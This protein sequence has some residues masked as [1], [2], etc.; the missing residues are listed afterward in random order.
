VKWTHAADIKAQLERD[1]LRGEICRAAVNT[2]EDFSMSI[3][4]ARPSAKVMLDEFSNMQDW[5]KEM[6]AFAAKRSVSLQWNAINHRVL[7]KQQLP[8]AVL[9]DS[10][11]QAAGLI[12]K[13]QALKQFIDL[14]KRTGKYFDRLQAWL[15]KHPLKALD[16]AQE[17]HRLLD[18]CGWMVTH[19]NPRVY[20][21]Q[22]DVAGVDSKF[23]EKHKRVL[24]E[25][26]D[27]ILPVYAIDDDFSGAV[28]FARR[29]GFLD[30]PVMLRTRPLDDKIALLHS[31]GNQDVVMRAKAFA[32]LDAYIF[33]QVKS[34]FIVENEINY[35]AFPNIPEA[36]LIFGSGY[37]FEALKRATWLQQCDVY[38][39]GDLDTHGFAIL[40]QLRVSFPDAQSFLMDQATMMN[41]QYA[42][43][44][45]PKQEKKDLQYLQP[46]E[47]TM[48]DALRWNRLGD[49]LRL[50]QERIAFVA[51]KK[52][53]EKFTTTR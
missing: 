28:G 23:I 18:V 22:V 25:M 40:N 51:V 29:F 34:V 52:A 42:W 14:F 9:L 50:E 11:Q 6:R 12:G 5:V 41:H 44:V 46:E 37:G 24:A 32:A 7:G 1:W 3:S 36:T 8:C 17:W 16:L 21:R 27:L 2:G 39:W 43:G 13:T 4:L 30:K 47:A 38:Y 26:F 20:L 15:V 48:Y 19:P 45:E 31:G 10:P 33:E 53:L 49:Q 35:L